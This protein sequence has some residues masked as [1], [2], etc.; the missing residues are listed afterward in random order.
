M[1]E[2]LTPV[3]KTMPCNYRT[4][5]ID[6]NCHPVAGETVTEDHWLRAQRYEQEVE[7]LTGRKYQEIAE[8][9]VLMDRD[10]L[11]TEELKNLVFGPMYQDCCAEAMDTVLGIREEDEEYD[12]SDDTE[13]SGLAD[14]ISLDFS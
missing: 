4:Q 9:S 10:D 2:S 7:R 1:L 6:F 8:I 5:P 3:A 13:D 12:S 11:D 14:E